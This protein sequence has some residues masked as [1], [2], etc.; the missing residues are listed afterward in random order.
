MRRKVQQRD[1]PLD[2]RR[3]KPSSSK[4]NQ[5]TNAL[6]LVQQLRGSPT[7]PATHSTHS[8]ATNTNTRKTNR[9][10]PRPHSYRA[11]L[12][13]QP[14]P[15]IQT[16]FINLN[17]NSITSVPSAS[18][19][20]ISSTTLLSNTHTH[21]NTQMNTNKNTNLTT[22]TT[23][24][25]SNN[26]R[27]NHSIDLNNIDDIT[28]PSRGNQTDHDNNDNP[29]DSPTRVRDHQ[30]L[31]RR[32]KGVEEMSEGRF[33]QLEDLAVKAGPNEITSG[34]MYVAL[35]LNLTEV[36]ERLW[37]SDKV[38]LILQNSKSLYIQDG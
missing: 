20:N 7:R 31:M 3:R 16:G 26:H 14:P 29:P 28:L 12:S 25:S 38:D 19:P 18:L 8:T 4:K 15:S 37:L 22:D 2:R 6:G 9:P 36:A 27:N 24:S 13:K 34:P 23:L 11:S 21:T 17:L 35:L 32:A 1:V 30:S 33:S 5:K 10:S